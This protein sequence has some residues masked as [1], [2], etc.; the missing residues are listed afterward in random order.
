MPS[1]VR[2]RSYFLTA[3]LVVAAAGFALLAPGC[4]GNKENNKLKVAYLGLTC[5][6][7]IFVADSKGFFK[8][9]G[10]EVELVK[11]D[12]NGLRELEYLSPALA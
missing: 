3:V 10:L 7:P 4:T 2:R 5:E 8:E 6:A 9:E 11:T 1:I 12:W